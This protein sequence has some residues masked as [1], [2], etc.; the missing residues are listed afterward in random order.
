MLTRLRNSPIPETD[1]GQI[2]LEAEATR[3]GSRALLCN[4]LASLVVSI[5]GPFF[6]SGVRSSRPYEIKGNS[7]WS[8]R[9]SRLWHERRTIDLATLWAI[10][11]GVFSTCMLSTL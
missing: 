5:V 1:D 11:H 4:A 3:L 9:V 7:D 10:S 6:V 8:S 2:A